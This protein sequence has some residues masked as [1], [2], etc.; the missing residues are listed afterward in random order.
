VKRLLLASMFVVVAVFADETK[1]VWSE[2]FEKHVAQGQPASWLDPSGRFRVHADGR[3]LVYG[4]EH[5]SPKQRSVGRSGPAAVPQGGA[6]STLSGRIFTGRDGF[7][8]RGR[9]RRTTAESL[10]GITFFSSQPELDTYHMVA[11]WRRSGDAAPVMRLYRRSD[12]LRELDSSELTPGVDRWYR[13]AIRTDRQ[14]GGNVIRARFWPDGEPEPDT[15]QLQTIDPQSEAP[16]GRIGL[17]S[18]YGASFFDD[19]SVSAEVEEDVDRVGP[20]IL[21]TEG[22]TTIVHGATAALNRDA[23]VGVRAL[24][25]SGVATL[26]VTIDD[27]PYESLSLISV[28][29]KHVLQA[30][31][32]DTVGNVSAA[33]VFVVIDKTPP[34]IRIVENGVAMPPTMLVNRDVVPSFLVDDATQTE[35]VATLDAQPFMTGTPVA[36]EGVHRLEITATDA[37]GW[38][39]SAMRTFAIDR[40]PPEMVITTPA[41]DE[42]IRGATADVTGRSGD[43]ESVLVNG[44]PAIAENG[45]FRR[46]GVPLSDGSNAITAVGSDAAGNVGR[47]SVRVHRDLRAP[48]V[49]IVAPETNG[50]L[51][52]GNIVVRGVVRNADSVQVRAGDGDAVTATITGDDWTATVPAAVEGPIVFVAEARGSGFTTTAVQPVL[53]DWTKPRIEVTE[54]GAS[55]S[56]TVFNRPLSIHLRLIDLDQTATIDASV[57]GNAFAAGGVLDQDGTY[58]LRATARDCAGNVADPV[59]LAFRI[60]RTPPELSNINPAHGAS[61]GSRMPVTGT[62]SEPGTVVDEASATTATVDGLAFTLPLPL[63]E[64]QNDRVLVVTDAAGNVARIPYT[65]RLRTGAPSVEI[66]ESG[67]P[68]PADAMFNRA[69]RPVVRVSDASASVVATMNGATFSSGTAVTEDGRYTVVATATDS[70]GHSSAPATATFTIDRTPPR[71][72]IT[73]PDDA[74]SVNGDRVEV[75]GTVDPDVR[76]VTVNGV[77]ASLAATSFTAS[78]GLEE[79]ANQVLAAAVDRAGNVGRDRVE[80]VRDAGRLALI[81]T[82]PP[83]EM[84]TNRPATVVAGRVLTQPPSGT[85]RVNDV[86]IP[87]DAGGNFRRIDFPLAEGDNDIVASV[88][89]ATGERTTVAVDVRAD[90]TPPELR[91]RANDAPLTEG[92]RFPV[93]PSITVEASDDLAAGVATELTIDG[94][95]IGGVVPDLGVGGHTLTAVARDAAG[96]EA[97]LDRTFFIGDTAAA[98]GCGLSEIDPASATAVFGELLRI[99]G[100]SGG[101]TG[102]LINGKSALVADGSFCGEASLQPGRNEVVI[103]CADSAGKPTQ[104]APIVLVVHRDAEPAIEI[105]SPSSGAETT[106]G[107]ITVSG[108]VSTEVVAGDVNGV[109]FEV[110]GTTF[111]APGIVLSPGLNA[112]VARARTGAGRTAID[113][114]SVTL[115]NAAPGVTITSPIVGTETGAASVDVTGAYVN[116]DPATIVVNGVAA[117]TTAATHASGTYRGT[118]ALA[119]GL[120]NTITVS[121]R[122][123]AGVEARASVEIQHFVAAPSISITAPLDLAVV[124]SGEVQVTGTVSAPDGSLVTVNGV[125]APVSAGAFSASAVLGAGTIPIIARVTTPGG[126]DAMDSVR[127]FHVTEALT[128]RQSFPAD[129]ATGVDRGVS[130]VLVFNRAVDTATVESSLRVTDSAGTVVAGRLFVD[131]DAATFAPHNPLRAGETYSIAFGGAARVFTTAATASQTAPIV[132]DLVTSGCFSSVKL[133]GRGS[134]GARVRVESDGITQTTGTTSTGSFQLTT[135]FSGRSGFHLVRIREIGSDGT[136]SAERAICFRTTCELLRV[137]AATLDRESRTLRIEF[138]RPIDPATVAFGTTIVIDPPVAG[139]VTVAGSI[140]TVSFAEELPPVNVVLTVKPAVKD[141]DGGSLAAEYTQSFAHENSAAERGK[142]YV[143]GAVFDATT[144]RPLGGATVTI[145]SAATLTNDRGRYSRALGEG[146]FTIAVTAEAY[147][148]AWRQIVVPA[149]AGVVPIDIRLTRRGPGLAS[150]GETSVT[151]RVEVTGAERVTAVGGQSLAGLLPLGWSPLA[152]AEV[153][154]VST[155]AKVMFDTGATSRPLTLVRYDEA[156]DEWR[157]VVAAAVP[158]EGRVVADVTRSGHY[159]LVY[160]DQAPRLREPPVPHAGDTLQGVANPC[161]DPAADCSLTSRA[162][163]LEP[164]AILPNGRAVATLVTEGAAQVYPSGTAVQATI[165][166]Q[167]NLADGRVLVDPPFATDLLLYRTLAGD[168]GMAD[169]HLAPTPRA[170]TVMLRDG[171]ERVRFVEYPRR[172]DRGTLLGA[173][174]GRVPGDG[175]VSIDVPPGSALE[176][177]HASTAALPDAELDAIGPV[178]G[179]RVAGGFS[180]TLTRAGAFPPIDGVV[181]ASPVL[182]IPARATFDVPG[183]SDAQVIVAEVLPDAEYGVL[184]RLVALAERAEGTLFATSAIDSTSL[185]LNGIVRNGRY[186]ILVAQ[187]PVAYAFGIVRA[188]AT[189]SALASARVTANGLGVSGHTGR[190]GLF[191]LPVPAKPAAPFVLIARSPQTGDGAPASAT[192]APDRGAFIDFGDLMLLAQPPVLRSVSPDGGEVSPGAGAVVRAEFD[193]EIDPA[194]APGA[195]RVLLQGTAGDVAGSVTAAGNSVTFTASEPL[196]AASLYSIVI[197]PSIRG[198]NGAPFGRTVTKAFRTSALPANGT[199]RPDL[200]RITVPD[201][202]GIVRIYGTTGALPAGAQAV[203]VRRDRDFVVRYQGTV[204]TDGAFSFQAGNGSPLDRIA[205]SDSIDL[206]VIDAV[207]RGTIAVVPLTPFASED[208]RTFLASPARDTVFL[209][210]DGFRVRVPAGAF[211]T[212]TPITVMRSSQ[213]AFLGVP[214]FDQE[215]GFGAAVELRFEGVA[216]R[217]I[218]LEIPVPDGLAVANRNW[219]V[220]Y[221]GQSIRGPRV[222]VVDLAYAS[223]GRFFTGIAPSGGGGR[224][225]ANAAISGSDLRTHFLGVQRSGVFALIDLRSTA[226]PVGFGLVDVFQQGYDLFWDTFEAL[227]A[228]HFYL[229]EGRGKVAMPVV[230]GAGFRLTGVDAATG[231]ER[232]SRTYEPI[233]IGDP[234]TVVNLPPPNDDREGPYPVSGSPFRIEI[235]DVTVKELSFD[236]VRDFSVKLSNGVITALPLNGFSLP[237]ALLNVTNGTFDASRDGGLSVR[238]E[239]GDRVV[240]L[241]GE[242]DVDPDAPLSVTF[243]EPIAAGDPA[244]LFQLTLDGVSTELKARL[245]AGG[246]RVMFDHPAA[247]MRGRTYRLEISPAVMDASKLQIGQTRDTKGIVTPALAEPLHLP[248]KVREPAGK[249][250]SF[251]L[252]GGSIRDQALV[253]NVLLVSALDAGIYAYDVSNPAGLGAGVAPLGHH[254]GDATSYW[255]L[256]HDHHGRVYATGMTAMMGVVRTFRIEDFVG[257]LDVKARGAASVSFNPGTAAALNVASRVIASDRPEAVPRKI[258]VVVSDREIEYSD[259]AKF[260]AAGAA[261]VNTSGDFEELRFESPFN[262]SLRYPVQRVT[263]ENV[264]LDMRWSADAMHGRP[265]VIAGIVARRDDR[266]RVLYNEFTYGLVTLLGYGISTIDLNAVEGGDAPVQPPGSVPMRELIRLTNGAVGAGCDAVASHAIPNLEFTP[267]GIVRATSTDLNVYALDPH[268]GVLDLRIRPPRTDIEAARPPDRVVCDERMSGTGLVLRNTIPLHDHPR[269]AKLRTLFEA[270]TGQVPHVRFSGAAAYSW[271][272]AAKDNAVV[273]PAGGPGTVALGQR[274]SPA[275][276]RVRRDYMLIPASD[277]G[278]L[279]VEVGGDAPAAAV[280]TGPALHDDLLV[281][282]VWIPGGAAAVRVLGGSSLATVTDRDG[283]V[284]VVD[285]ARLDERFQTPAGELFPTARSILERDVTIPD[286]RII[287][288]SAEPLASGT[289]APVVD[290]ATGFIFAARLLE[291]T[292]NVISAF[293]PRLQLHAERPPP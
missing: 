8:L 132:D 183:S 70:V 239:P 140:A 67:D 60:D 184:V 188:G 68:I 45:T 282:V 107:T 143:S 227:Y 43:A 116:V 44:L 2:D 289:L 271:S 144:G 149:G 194:S 242:E 131:R 16:A 151:R 215:I 153:L 100:R 193:R 76:S 112:I 277:Y 21:F 59:D 121:G 212:P 108:S 77:T 288:R 268:R 50:C 75:R 162:F 253:G 56:G 250:A 55:L 53:I 185:P 62:M 148:P 172:L 127:V 199:V 49:L 210:A 214:R 88:M 169:F 279:V 40:T 246:R 251:D 181:D 128:I 263:V 63:E 201:A 160:P 135:T 6:F 129:G 99:A 228:A 244:S 274:G 31:A 120:T 208:L 240:L 86:D 278:L 92:A 155:V 136:F 150:G 262:P 291:K 264:S 273:T 141:V 267:D 54:S 276:E 252:A 130:I 139:S 235:V 64:G 12:G 168:A 223:N 269:L 97:R 167:L 58:T 91:V 26:R 82:S 159:A 37:V 176:P 166:E 57:N 226:G 27:A 41:A 182:L 266:V 173:E 42:R 270:R 52:S 71:V 275:N 230:L 36:A 203:A 187:A 152:A 7:E 137:I 65:V 5:P 254:P 164:R 178:A 109:P 51:S 13:F 195:I 161:L 221:L 209:S 170:A 293:D 84:L 101:A 125:A 93:S 15:W 196:R 249:V 285:L 147:V 180:L 19:L 204:S 206:H 281:D 192:S 104:D 96:N 80:V 117:T 165:D 231:L 126:E 90:F 47:A 35:V 46:A 10:A 30:R 233:V 146:A 171:V 79:G 83:D 78:I 247:L 216:Q 34:S 69:A 145:G 222:M 28:E 118:A 248:F 156:R 256:A 200:V 238:G 287:W 259:R 122:N 190:T 73:S 123:S 25:A 1:V 290:P 103:Q 74:A 3:N 39:S 22:D 224:I 189:G 272:L 158:V 98:G 225:A 133:T 61:I 119:P 163:T 18:A 157:V 72:D 186:L 106:S 219:L 234:G 29:K 9:F 110:S 20:A 255:A 205:T 280:A 243:S 17:W 211:N 245:D 138:S 260:K 115:R 213:S 85:V 292:T 197:A 11:L 134:P 32:T 24:D 4:A 286:P 220:G 23:R 218:E 38:T 236:S 258:Q 207:S 154:G 237:A 174:G 257:S 124:S 284:L 14:T 179:F 114:T 66:V 177:L 229:S 102:V 81:L 94:A 113:T 105:T 33:T 283:Y 89:S 87:V 217:R 202:D 142:G 232:F 198:F 241:I 95:R 261:L 48:E 191:V 175:R 265:A 111:T